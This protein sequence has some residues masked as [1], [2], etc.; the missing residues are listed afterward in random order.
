MSEFLLWLLCLVDTYS[1]AVTTI[2]TVLMA[3]FTCALIYVSR[4]QTRI[5]KIQSRAFVFLDGFATELS[6]LADRPDDSNGIPLPPLTDK[7]LHVTR[8]AMQPRWKN[9]GNTPTKNMTLKV[10]RE[11][12]DEGLPPDFAYEY[13]DSSI[14]H[15]FLASK[16]TEPS[17]FIETN[18]TLVNN[19][20]NNGLPIVK[21]DPSIFIWGRADYKDA[22]DKSHFVEWCYRVR[23]DRPPDGR[24]RASYTQWGKYN[25]TD[26]D[27]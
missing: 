16:A 20:I 8:F 13:G 17:E 5:F 1:G 22:F 11:Y 9:A 10:N 19:V 7:R 21:G 23:F 27:I 18:P 2:A 6:T 15:R 26:Q 24:L 25:R 12:F 4:G 3:A 14:V